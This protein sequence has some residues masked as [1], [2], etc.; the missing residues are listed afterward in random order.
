VLPPRHSCNDFTA[1][2]WNDDG[3][4]VL[5][6]GVGVGSALLTAETASQALRLVLGGTFTRFPKLKI[7]LGHMGE[8]FSFLL[9]RMGATGN[10]SSAKNSRRTQVQADHRRTSVLP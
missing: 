4:N 10:A 7:I 2:A 9:W 3:Y 6:N 8:T 5:A 1:C